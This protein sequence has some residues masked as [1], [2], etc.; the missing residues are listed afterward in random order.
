MKRLMTDST[1][2]KGALTPYVPFNI[3]KWESQHEVVP[4][5]VIDIDPQTLEKAKLEDLQ[6]LADP[7]KFDEK[8]EVAED[9]LGGVR[10]SEAVIYG[11]ALM[12]PSYTKDMTELSLSSRISKEDLDAITRLC[13]KIVLSRL[14]E[15]IATTATPSG[16]PKT[17]GE[18]VRQYWASGTFDTFWADVG[19]EV[20]KLLGNK[21]SKSEI[22]EYLQALY[23]EARFL[24][25]SP[26]AQR[27]GGK[28]IRR[29]S[30]L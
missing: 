20:I 14:K 29:A 21:A 5:N 13:D 7:S 4:G 19:S 25:V 18:A 2:N 11:S 22:R 6:A 9:A 15:Q 26:S 16:K 24:T 30:S 23:A 27:E 17:I 3:T 12:L 28:P 10:C 1:Y 8:E